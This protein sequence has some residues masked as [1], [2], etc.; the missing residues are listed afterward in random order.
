MLRETNKRFMMKMGLASDDCLVTDYGAWGDCTGGA[1]DG[2]GKQYR[3][4][5][6]KHPD[7]A[8]KCRRKLFETKTCIMPR[9]TYGTIM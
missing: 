2:N 4:R 5:Y 8:T 7:K 3:Q 1:C 6:Y 9:C